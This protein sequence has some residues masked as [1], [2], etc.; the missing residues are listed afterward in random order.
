MAALLT[1]GGFIIHIYMSVFLVPGSGAAMLFGDVPA[2]WAR[3]HH[4]L[5]YQRISGGAGTK[6]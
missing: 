2:A 3:T 4:R 1:I 6:E 5:W